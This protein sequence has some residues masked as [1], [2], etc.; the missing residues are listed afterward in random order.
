M[1]K[2]CERTVLRCWKNCKNLVSITKSSNVLLRCYRSD[3]SFKRKRK[4]ITSYQVPHP[5]PERVVQVR[6]PFF[7]LRQIAF[8]ADF[9]PLLFDP[10]NLQ[11]PTNARK[12]S[13]FLSTAGDEEQV[14]KMSNRCGNHDRPKGKRTS[15]Q[16][17]IDVRRRSASHG[18]IRTCLE[19]DFNYPFRN[20]VNRVIFGYRYVSSRRSMPRCAVGLRR[21]AESARPTVVV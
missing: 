18:V 3:I 12:N 17:T 21:K 16:W 8:D 11:R 2:S 9:R 4:N 20:Y 6:V 19:V 14:N 7:L 10:Q 5:W 1:S 13:R 15:E